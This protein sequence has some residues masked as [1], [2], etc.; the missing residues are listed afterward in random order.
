MTT[1]G[2]THHLNLPALLQWTMPGRILVF[3]LAATSI[4]CLLAEMYG[5]CDMRTFTLFILL[6][7]T[8]AL[9]GLAVFDRLRGDRRLWRG[10]IIGTLAGLAGAIVYDVVRLPFAFSKAWG[11][12]A[13]VPQMPLFKVFPRFGALILG[14]PL[15]QPSYSLGAHLLGWV[16][17][18][19]NGATFGVMFAALIGEATR[20]YGSGW[21]WAVVLAVGI[22][23]CL[24][25]SPYA[26]FFH[27]TLNARFVT[28]TLLAHLVFGVGM[29]L[30]FAWHAR[31]WRLE[32][33]R[34]AA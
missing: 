4:W 30:Y 5:V 22:E 1:N 12:E 18:F 8:V 25:A 19:S 20:R 15:E 29:G 10:V 33:A 13:V 2:P 21:L 32:S 24:L 23:I 34:A 26:K 14:E 28:V 11:L 6:P 17:H 27:I 9:Y 31:W 3:F 7:A 16:Y